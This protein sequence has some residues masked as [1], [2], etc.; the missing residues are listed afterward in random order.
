[1]L[2]PFGAQNVHQLC[3]GVF[4]WPREENAKSFS[5]NDLARCEFAD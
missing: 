1:M 4:G 3:T 2:T 5:Q